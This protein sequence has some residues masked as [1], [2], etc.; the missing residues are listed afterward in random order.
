MSHLRSQGPEGPPRGSEGPALE[1]DALLLDLDGTLLD[2]AGDLTTALNRTL[3]GLERSLV[4]EEQ[5]REWIGDGVY[6][7]VQ[8]GL[9]ATGGDSLGIEEEAYTRFFASYSECLGGQSYPY[10]GVK[11]T[12]ASLHQIG[13][14][15]A[16]VTN[17]AARFTRPLLE[18]TGIMSYLQLV[19]SGDTLPE[20]KPDAAPVTYAA[21]CLGI[22]PSRMV[23]VGDSLNDI[24]A[25][26]RAGCFVVAVTYGYCHGVDP[27]TMGADRVITCFSALLEQIRFFGVKCSCQES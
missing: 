7:L 16:V 26:R 3:V 21:R 20:K 25:G 5:V 19:I 2:T 6:K 15:M 11:A 1:A 4:K 9:E 24:Q 27:Y 17:K 13:L 18:A 23:V 10:P 14:P 8:R 12:L 22:E